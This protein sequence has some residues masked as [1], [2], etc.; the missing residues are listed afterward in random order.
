MNYLKLNEK[1]LKHH[2]KNKKRITLSLIV[3][4]MITGGLGITEEE[5][6]ARDLRP[7]QAKSNIRP[8]SGG[9][10]LDYAGQ[11]K[12]DVV[13]IVAPGQGG[14]SHNKFID[15]SVGEKGVIFNNN[16]TED[17]VTSK[18]GG[19]VNK[20]NK[21]NGQEASAIL[22][23]VTGN[24]S[25]YL[26]GPVE[27]AGKKADFILANENGISVNG[28]GF[29]NTNGVTLTTGKV[30]TNGGNINVD[31]TKGN[32][33]IIGQGVETAGNYF[34]VISQTIELYGQVAA[35]TGE[36]DANLNFI[37]GNN[38]VNSINTSNPQIAESSNLSD[39]AIK[40]GI[41]AG[42][43]GAMYGNNIR[44]ISTAHG[45]GVKHEG[46]IR[47]KGDINIDAKGD[48]TIGGLTSEKNINVKGTGNLDTINGVYEVEGKKYNYGISSKEGIILSVDGDMTF[49][50]FITA[51]G[52]AG[53]EVSAQNLKILGDKKTTSGILAEGNLILKVTGDITTDILLRP[54]GKDNTVLL[55]VTEEDGSVKVIDP[56]SGRT[57]S[58]SEYSWVGTGIQG[59]KID[60][61]SKTFTN[62]TSIVNTRN[63]MDET[64][65][66]ISTDDKFL[67]R[68]SVYSSG[69]LEINSKNIENIKGASLQGADIKINGETIN[70]YGEIRQ[71]IANQGE[72]TNRLGGIKINFKNG[73]FR[74]EGTVSGY[75][76]EID[77]QG[78]NL[79]NTKD[80]KIVASTVDYP[81][82][83]GSIT[84]RV[85]DLSSEG[86]IQSYGSGTQN[87]I[88]I[89]VETLS[90]IF[91]YIIAQK[92]DVTITSTGKI[93]N[94]GEI[95]ADKS[96]T[97]SSTGAS[98]RNEGGSSSIGAGKNVSITAKN[99]E[100]VNN[101]KI[102]AAE[103]LLVIV[104]ELLNSGTSDGLR[105]YLKAF[106]NL[107]QDGTKK[108]DEIIT[109]LEAK[110]KTASAEERKILEEKINLFK[111][112][113]EQLKDFNDS[114]EVLPG[115]G[116]MSANSIEITTGTATQNNGIVK[117]NEDIKITSDGKINNTGI[118]EAGTDVTLEAKG[119]IVNSQR[120]Y[121]G[122]K[123]DITGKS[124]KATGSD[125]LLT[126]YATALNDFSKAGGD[127]KLDELNKKIA[128]LEAQLKSGTESAGLQNT[129]AELD[130]LI[131][132]RKSLAALKAKISSLAEKLENGKDGTGLSTI[133]SK[134]VNLNLKM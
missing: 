114:L 127:A 76:V 23:E 133:E 129:K 24:N 122:N 33:S 104:N 57:L 6:L 94:S 106:Y 55:L 90:N 22:N 110:L 12:I 80:G 31:V 85:K 1:L 21:L 123:I 108:I 70:N 65:I 78:F 88:T 39:S 44:L 25:S 89:D 126:D 63:L 2:L 54:V 19:I 28:A 68:G 52:K 38:K 100:L 13:N 58:D 79:V 71:N 115:I 74:N 132:E 17:Y 43:L 3:T 69:S 42:P 45:L 8:E 37:A 113:K 9:P 134:N 131:N 35:K 59:E 102:Y 96:V 124:F 53:L 120:I 50:N 20:N 56:V 4:F 109:E 27:I 32:I 11:E 84:I 75:A 83:Q 15:F 5:I 81:A 111:N 93:I 46:I 30:S 98:I 34:N 29:I 128:D 130:K 7:R 73:T 107:G 116:T 99:A 97:I 118:L 14:I 92:G 51:N 121:A 10:T 103:K 119:D 64:F 112:L 95:F 60:I 101:G 77:G 48:I 49:R 91:G 18:L 61:S 72:S 82:G 66:K 105:E 125:K 36:Y 26:D 16:A 117:A 87:N 67:N 40:Y 41:H 62:N 86:I 47:S